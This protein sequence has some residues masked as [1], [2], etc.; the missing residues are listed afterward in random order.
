[1]AILHYLHNFSLSLNLFDSEH[2]IFKKFQ[3]N[4]YSLKP[5]LSQ[6]KTELI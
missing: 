1:M 5:C 2:F 4:M 6:L 3:G